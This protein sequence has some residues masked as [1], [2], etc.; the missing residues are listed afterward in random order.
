M[1]S[2]ILKVK[3]W[4]TKKPDY[5]G[6]VSHLKEWDKHGIPHGV[7]DIKRIASSYGV[8]IPYMDSRGTL[9]LD[10]NIEKLLCK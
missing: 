9:V 3:D 1:K 8:P 10:V 6:F 2:R 5:N 4:L 7:S